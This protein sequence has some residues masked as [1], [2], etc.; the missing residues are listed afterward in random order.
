MQQIYFIFL[1]LPMTFLYQIRYALKKYE[2]KRIPKAITLR[3]LNK[4]MFIQIATNRIIPAIH[5]PAGS[6]LRSRY[7]RFL[8]W[9]D[10]ILIFS[11]VHLCENVF[12]PD[13]H[14]P[15]R[16]NYFLQNALTFFIKSPIKNLLIKFL[17]VN[18]TIFCIVRRNFSPVKCLSSV[19]GLVFYQH[20]GLLWFHCRA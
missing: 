1:F 11:T 10:S 3:I 16:S 17:R 20:D 8:Q 15:L 7:R 18:V 13:P 14:L 19:Y 2:I 9:T 6:Y 4:T 5:L 12:L